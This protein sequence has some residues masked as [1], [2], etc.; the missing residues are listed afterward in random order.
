[1][2]EGRERGAGP[3]PAH[4]AMTVDR[5]NGIGAR[6]VA[7]GTAK[8]ATLPVHGLLHQRK[9]GLQVV[10]EQAPAARRAIPERVHVAARASRSGRRRRPRGRDAEADRALR[11]SSG[12][13]SAEQA[14]QPD[15]AGADP[16]RLPTRRSGHWRPRPP[17][18]QDRKPDSSVVTPMPSPD[19]ADARPSAMVPQTRCSRY[20][21]STPTQAARAPCRAA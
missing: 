11:F 15:Q 13:P 4:R 18:G 12:W 1:M 8:T 14:E 19:R 7:D 21:S 6:P 20:S 9:N 16:N 10:P 2:H 3:A 17:Q 5:A